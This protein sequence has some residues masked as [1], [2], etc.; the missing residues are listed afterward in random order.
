MS[1]FYKNVIMVAFNHKMI[2]RKYEKNIIF[3]FKEKIM[4][5]LVVFSKFRALS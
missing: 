5:I 2:I 4:K 3:G 1:V